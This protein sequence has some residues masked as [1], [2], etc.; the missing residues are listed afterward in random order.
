MPVP[1]MWRNQKRAVIY[2]DISCRA[3]SQV[4]MCVLITY[5][6]NI[7]QTAATPN[8]QNLVNPLLLYSARGA[9]CVLHAQ[10]CYV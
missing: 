4:L 5:R 2:A 9:C 3:A 7:Y 8:L 10:T 6:K 1:S